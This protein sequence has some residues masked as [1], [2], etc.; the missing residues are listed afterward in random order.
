MRREI[1]RLERVEDRTGRP[2]RLPFL[3][4]H[5]AHALFPEASAMEPGKVYCTQGLELPQC[6]GFCHGFTRGGKA[7]SNERPQ[8]ALT[9]CAHCG[10][11]E[12]PKTLDS[13]NRRL[14]VAPQ[15]A[16]ALSA[17][18]ATTAL[19]VFMARSLFI[20]ADLHNVREAVRPRRPI[21]GRG[22][23][24]DP[25]FLFSRTSRYSHV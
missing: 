25:P 4:R 8:K 20:L 5:C 15:R 22:A 21:E 11:M 7:Y 23:L 24:T 6:G 18:I 2:F 1:F 12:A 10:D 9:S 13:R 17:F 16:K 3:C 14:A 19:A